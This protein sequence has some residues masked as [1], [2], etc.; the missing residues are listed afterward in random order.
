MFQLRSYENEFKIWYICGQAKIYWLVLSFTLK[1]WMEKGEKK[2]WVDEVFA[3]V[4]KTMLHKGF[5]E[6]K[7]GDEN[8]RY[9]NGNAGPISGDRG[10]GRCMRSGS[11]HLIASTLS[12]WPLGSPNALP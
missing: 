10:K 5:T 12:A 9:K 3:V 2:T 8:K 7:N 4:A 11:W 6:I 1:C